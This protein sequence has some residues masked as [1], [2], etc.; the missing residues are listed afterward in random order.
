MFEVNNI[1]NIV[2]LETIF[3]NSF[4]NKKV[5]QKRRMDKIEFEG[6]ILDTT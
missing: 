5:L 2:H 1:Y 6:T 3:F 4:V